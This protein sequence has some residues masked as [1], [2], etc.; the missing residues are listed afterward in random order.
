MEATYFK[1]FGRF[2]LLVL[3]KNSIFKSGG[4]PQI[5]ERIAERFS[6]F[7]DKYGACGNLFVTVAGLPFRRTLHARRTQAPFLP[8]FTRS[9][10]LHRHTPFSHKLRAAQALSAA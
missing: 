5:E 1:N 7:E 9:H 10:D 6:D 8:F 4:G 2:A 3:A